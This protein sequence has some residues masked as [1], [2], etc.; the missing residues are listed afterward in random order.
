MS[1]S[2]CTGILQ[3]IVAWY[4][5]R[6]SPVFACFLDASKAF[7]LVR[8]DILFEQL[9]S[10]GLPS[11]VVRLLHSWYVEQKLRVKWRGVFSDQFTVANG[12]RQGGVLSPIL[13]SIYLDSLLNDLQRR[14]IGCFWDHHFV[15]ALAYADDVVLLAPCPSALRMQI[16]E[17]FASSNG[18]YF[19]PGKTQLIKFSLFNSSPIKAHFVFVVPVWFFNPQFLI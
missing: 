3:N 18:L 4:N 15:G 7:D 11:V 6:G 5:Q 12:V 17:R 8:H 13:F 19:N 9:L 14:G 16:C 1:S 2:H 10:R